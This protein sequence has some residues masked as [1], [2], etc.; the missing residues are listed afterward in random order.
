MNEKPKTLNPITIRRL[1]A[2]RENYLEQLKNAQQRIDSKSW[3]ALY[4]ANEI[5]NIENGPDNLGELAREAN[6]QTISQQ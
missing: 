3:S 2:L 4:I 5:Q 1:I 6:P